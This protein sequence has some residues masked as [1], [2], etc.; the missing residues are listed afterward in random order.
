[1]CYS[2]ATGYCSAL[3]NFH[4]DWFSGKLAKVAPAGAGGVG[5]EGDTRPIEQQS[6]KSGEDFNFEDFFFAGG[7]GDDEDEDVKLSYATPNGAKNDGGSASD[8]GDED[9]R[10]GYG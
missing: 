3:Y 5:G 2:C 7:A 10:Y 1:M 4:S 9:Q 8:S 6:V